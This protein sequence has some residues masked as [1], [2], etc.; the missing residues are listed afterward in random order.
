MRRLVYDCSGASID[1]LKLGTQSFQNSYWRNNLTNRL[2]L[3]SLE[4]DFAHISND[5]TNSVEVYTG[6]FKPPVDGLYSFSMTCDNYCELYLSTVLNSSEVSNLQ[7]LITWKPA[8]D[9]LPYNYNIHRSSQISL[10]A[11]SYYL[12]QGFKSLYTTTGSIKVGVEIPQEQSR[13]MQSIQYIRISYE[14]T[15]EK[16]E[17]KAYN[18]KSGTFKIVIDG[19][20]PISGDNVYHKETQA[21]DYNITENN[22]T[23]ILSSQLGWGRASLKKFHLDKAGQIISNNSLLNETAGFFFEINLT[24]YRDSYQGNLFLPKI[25]I[26][27]SDTT[28]ITSFIQTQ[29]PT[30]FITGEYTLKFGDT[31]MEHIQVNQS[32]LIENLKLIPEYNRYFT[33]ELYG[34]I[35]EDRTY[36][37]KFTG[38]KESVPLIEVITSNLQGGNPGTSPQIFASVITE[39]SNTI[40][41]DTIPYDLIYQADS[42]PQVN[43]YVNGIASKC[44]NDNCL[45]Q[46]SNEKTPILRDYNLTSDG[47]SLLL[48][49]YLDYNITIENVQIHFALTE[50]VI[51]NINL[52]YLKCSI[53]LNS[54][55]NLS[56]SCGTYQPLIHIDNIGFV[57]YDRSLKDTTINLTIIALN[58]T[59]GSVMGGQNIAISGFGFPLNGVSSKIGNSS[60]IVLESSNNQ[61]LIQTNPKIDFN[62][63]VV[64]F[65]SQTAYNDDFEYSD[66]ITPIINSISLNSSSPV[67]KAEIKIQG[68]GFGD[69]L[70]KIKVFLDGRDIIYELSAV[71]IIN[72]EILA[73]LGGGKAGKYKVRVVISDIGSSKGLSEDIN[74][75][76]YELVILGI[77][78]NRGSV[79]G[80][81]LLTITGINFS[82]TL[83]QNQVFIGDD[84]NQFCDIVSSNNTEIKCKTRI[85]PDNYLEI[86]QSL[87]VTQRVQEE[88]RCGI[89]ECSFT[90]SRDSTPEILLK[91]DEN[92]M[93][94]KGDLITLNGS[95]LKLPRDLNLNGFVSFIQ[96]G[97]VKYKTKTNDLQENNLTFA[98]PAMV[99]GLYSILI[100]I[101]N[102]G[103][104]MFSHKIILNNTFIIKDVTLNDGN[105][106]DI[107]GSKGGV[108]LNI[109]GNGFGEN[110]TILIQNTVGNCVKLNIYDP[111]R[112]IC[113]TKALPTEGVNYTINLVR[114]T[115]TI[116]CEKCTFQVANSSTPL[117]LSHNASKPLNQSNFI[118]NL[119]GSMLN[120]SNS[121]GRIVLSLSEESQLITSHEAQILF[122]SSSNIIVSFSNVPAGEYLLNGYFKEVG[123]FN[124]PTALKI[125]FINHYQINLN[126]NI[127][128]F[129]YFGGAN[130]T[131]SSSEVL[132]GSENKENLNVTICGFLCEIIASRGNMLTCKTPIIKTK[133]TM[134]YSSKRKNKEALEKFQVSGDSISTL[135][136]VIDGN[137]STY[138]DS[139]NDFC[140]IGFDFGIDF[141][142]YIEQIDIFFNN[143][144]ILSDFYGLVLQYSL[145]GINYTDLLTLG[146]DT[147]KSGKN[148][149]EISE[150]IPVIRSIRLQSLVQKHTSR[151]SL[152]EVA[153]YGARL[154]KNST[155]SITSQTCDVKFS[156]YNYQIQFNQSVQFSE[157]STPKISSF[158]PKIGTTL[159]G[160]NL[161]INGSNFGGDLASIE[162]EI[163]GVK[164]T[165]SSVNSSAIV[166]V[167]GSRYL[168]KNK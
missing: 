25:I 20:D 21:L 17:L 46:I 148:K 97:V 63:I 33:C 150:D 145:N 119:K 121:P 124:I 16:L 45:Y 96:E 68:T 85:A 161:T 79:L 164:C 103:I 88:S 66:T 95:K 57:V 60:A 12:I 76:Y 28:P 147:I 140:W 105:S 106:M 70:E 129:G 59:K 49:N 58:A 118:L 151:C 4:N 155:D 131:F 144:R 80:G 54:D 90:Y 89:S 138:Y 31:L 53:P 71:S 133:K 152:A 37:I 10:N 32:S 30:P 92:F 84:V 73:I 51:N 83:N 62:R 134:S 7:N 64:S 15:R 19:R 101:P 156:S 18:W 115:T 40:V 55:G 5:F 14:P 142:T 126:K 34:S 75:F 24:L 135:K 23:S 112:I 139:G 157:G 52:P 132:F 26:I 1:L 2:L 42:E 78:P 38:M 168:F 77:R 27:S 128:P 22:L 93:V 74:T 153:F 13:L 154:Y 160:T 125:V 110:D 149:F 98:V 141:H 123:F 116:S 143:R 6:Y 44:Q 81:T 86:N 94:N 114:N 99:G 3:D 61:I 47:L 102:K 109:S 67:Q 120:L 8:R 43:V 69:S 111:T 87:I 113:K 163:D 56:L 35:N 11:N 137:P 100:E 41:Y 130:L 82:P 136:K 36:V 91:N 117:I 158:I 167:T 72:G 65:N 146:P 50:C 127:K 107:L 162:V 29:V 159:G 39:S 108:I 165:V 104:V 9:G 48:D 122:V 166:C